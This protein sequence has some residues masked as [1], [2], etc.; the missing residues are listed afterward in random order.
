MI[1]L[2]DVTFTIP[3]KKDTEERL[4]NLNIVV[5]FIR[6]HFDTNIIVCEM[7]EVQNLGKSNLY[8]YLYIK[9]NNYIMHRTHCL[10]VMAKLAK[11]PIIVN[12]DTDV[13]FPL[14]QYQNA[15]EA[16]R[17]NVSDMVFPYG[18]KFV[19][20][21]EPHISFI[22]DTLTLDGIDESKGS[23]YHP[24]SVGGA[25]FF[26]KTKF[27]QGGMENEN[28]ISWGW[29]DNERV[30][31]FS[32]LGFRINRVSGVL[33]HLNHPTSSNS[34]NTQHEYYIKNQQELHR[35]SS[36]SPEQ[37]RAYINTWGWIR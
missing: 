3:F 18:G 1:N 32:K 25:I 26:N 9:A 22:K 17:Q 37:L 28:F 11:T 8:D 35:V 21:T 16:I 7:D 34:S 33:Y 27:I 19:N 4:R 30:T 20:L 23:V 12:Y 15:T 24:N 6:R 5:N 10:N 2:K 29:E 14:H 13:V 36:M 31:R